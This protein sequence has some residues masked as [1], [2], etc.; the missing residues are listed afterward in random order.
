MSFSDTA[1][2]FISFQSFNTVIY[3]V[4]L[5]NK[6]TERQYIQLECRLCQI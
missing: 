3:D 2:N 6:H 4:I 5:N 1:Q